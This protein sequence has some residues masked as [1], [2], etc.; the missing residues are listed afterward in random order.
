MAPRT[1]PACKQSEPDVPFTAKGR[2]CQPCQRLRGK[3]WYDAHKDEV[4]AKAKASYA[5]NSEPAKARARAWKDEHKEQHVDSV[6][7]WQKANPTKTKAN[8]RRSYQAN[9]ATV[10]LRARAW[11]KANPDKK[12]AHA[13]N[14]KARRRSRYKATGRVTGLQ[15]RECLESFN[16]C[17]AYCGASD[18]KLTQDHMTPISRGGAH[19]IENVVPACGPCNSKKCDR[20][21]LSMVNEAFHLRGLTNLWRS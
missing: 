21:P 4:S 6:M 12:Q 17:C 8:K 14:I 15:W 11:D 2:Y 18:R 16:H 3:A 10:R 13:A 1:C 9:K 20:G 7:A 5:A 19:S